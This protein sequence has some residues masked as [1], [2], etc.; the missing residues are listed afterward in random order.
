MKRI[1]LISILLSIGFL[2]LN[3]QEEYIRE[4]NSNTLSINVPTNAF[5]K[6]NEYKRKI[7][8]GYTLGGVR[9]T[10]NLEYQPYD[11]FSISVGVSMLRYW[12]ANEYSQEDF[13]SIPYY[14]DTNTQKQL[15]WKPFFRFNYQIN[16]N[17]HF[18]IGN[19][20]TTYSHFLP[21]PLYNRE[22]VYSSDGEEGL[23]LIYRS[24]YW[25][26]D[27]WINW[28]N[29]NF[30]NDIDRESFDFGT[31][32]K[33]NTNPLNKY[34]LSLDYSFI[35]HHNG[36]ELDTISTAV[37]DH[38][39]NGN[40]GVSLAINNLFNADNTLSLHFDYLFSKDMKNS[41]L[42]LDN[43]YAFFPYIQFQNKNINTT[44]GYYDSKNMITF[45]GTN[46]FS[47]LAQRDKNITYPH[48]QMIYLAF[49]YSINLNKNNTNPKQL[50]DLSIVSEFFYKLDNNNSIETETKGL[51]FGLGFILTAKNNFKIK[52][53][54]QLN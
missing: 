38:W 27:A 28:Q 39:A 42:P 8:Y 14:T 21:V 12:G 25:T 11:N 7:A 32:G 34:L 22:L 41:T 24:K 40:V 30:F 43:G 47:N 29:F 53:F 19:L 10:P 36:G 15:H 2:S 6:N 51:S 26:N 31:A 18:I 35:W 3:A 20:L 46:F 4:D 50:Y 13:V 44:L 23:Q 45:Y 33:I 54:K 49:D 48:N 5:F 16:N 1:T 17:L 52:Q 9:I 37:L